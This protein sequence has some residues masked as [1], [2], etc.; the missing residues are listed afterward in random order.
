MASKRRSATR[1][2]RSNFLTT[3]R[4]VTAG[5]GCCALGTD[6]Q[7]ECADSHPS[8]QA[9]QL[10]ERYKREVVN[11][12][13][14]VCDDFY[15]ADVGEL[16]HVLSVCLNR[17]ALTADSAWEGE[18]Q[19]SRVH[20]M[21]WAAPLLPYVRDG[22]L[23]SVNCLLAFDLHYH[24]TG[25]YGGA[26]MLFADF[27]WA[28]HMCTLDMILQLKDDM[29]ELAAVQDDSS[30]SPSLARVASLFR[31]LIADSDARENLCFLLCLAW[32][33]V[34]LSTMS[35]CRRVYDL[36]CVPEALRGKS[37]AEI[38]R[39]AH[40]IEQLFALGPLAMPAFRESFQNM[41][42]L[43]SSKRVEVF[44]SRGRLQP[45]GPLHSSLAER[46]CVNCGHKFTIGERD[47]SVLSDHTGRLMTWDR[48]TCGSRS[49]VAHLQKLQGQV[50][51]LLKTFRALPQAGV[52]IPSAPFDPDDYCGPL[53]IETQLFDSA[54]F[55]AEMERKD[56]TDTTRIETIALWYHED[57]S[58]YGNSDVR[59]YS[60]E[61]VFQQACANN[62]F[63][64]CQARNTTYG[65][66]LYMMHILDVEY[67]TKLHSDQYVGQR[68]KHA[69]LL[70]IWE[71]MYSKVSGTTAGADVDAVQ[72]RS[73]LLVRIGTP[74]SRL[75][76]ELLDE[77]Q[78]ALPTA[79]LE[80]V[81]EEVF[82]RA[83]A[84]RDASGAV[85]ELGELAPATDISRRF[86]ILHAAEVRIAVGER[87][88]WVPGGAQPLPAPFWS[89]LESLESLN[90]PGVAEAA[91]VQS[92][93]EAIRPVWTPRRESEHH[94]E[95][96]ERHLQP[97]DALLVRRAA[98]TVRSIRSY[99]DTFSPTAMRNYSALRE[100]IWYCLFGL[101]GA[102]RDWHPDPPHGK[103]K[104]CEAFAAKRDDLF[105][106]LR[107]PATPADYTPMQT[108]CLEV[109][110]L[111]AR[112][113]DNNV[114]EHC[115]YPV[116]LDLKHHPP[117]LAHP[118]KP[119]ETD[120]TFQ[121]PHPLPRWGC[122]CL[123]KPRTTTDIYTYPRE[124]D[125]DHLA[126]SNQF[127]PGD[128]SRSDLCFLP[129]EDVIVRK[130]RQT[131]W[132]NISFH[133][134]ATRRLS[135]LEGAPPDH[136][137][138]ILARVA[139]KLIPRKLTT[140]VTFSPELPAARLEDL[141]LSDGPE[142]V[143]HHV[144]GNV[145][146][147]GWRNHKLEKYL[148]VLVAAVNA[149]RVTDGVLPFHCYLCGGDKNQ[150]YELP[151]S[152]NVPGLKGE[153]PLSPLKWRMSRSP[154]AGVATTSIQVVFEP[155]GCEK[156]QSVAAL[157]AQTYE[158]EV[159]LE[160]ELEWADV[161]PTFKHAPAG[162]CVYTSNRSHFFIPCELHPE[163]A[164]RREWRTYKWERIWNAPII[165][166]PKSD[167]LSRPCPGM[168]PGFVCCGEVH[169]H[170]CKHCERVGAREKASIFY[171]PN[172]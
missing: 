136:L 4:L 160:V 94:A 156:F 133:E 28:D 134:Y 45:D 132:Q 137:L 163:N 24:E 47:C 30:S 87:T 138:R 26:H 104:G 91:H 170:R 17:L 8:I 50:V 105:Y 100:T 43:E 97:A 35:Y 72:R 129:P 32:H 18:R 90:G 169:K 124:G 49:Q 113:M 165:R 120:R 53:M 171:L 153:E 144:D 152:A 168:V 77:M 111:Y 41:W 127:S 131:F 95:E 164:V 150:P 56:V 60:A 36:H 108:L 125:I 31:L 145:G 5:G 103:Y 64:L 62:C 66:L 135:E 117:P 52:A 112:F 11:R 40:H 16:V 14:D 99:L 2:T 107:L 106:S 166:L 25:G 79:Q 115:K 162:M 123:L 114:C 34:F 121:N 143:T 116:V 10:P 46:G 157:A 1:S 76:K 141:G 13:R 84:I 6:L 149:M 96:D 3:D 21:A 33:R 81:W 88:V 86:S 55:R 89:A 65:D 19:G 126:C 159:E 70:T 15:Q 48:A 161:L 146:A 109:L 98:G 67:V 155:S 58:K 74:L 61:T 92:A 78:I 59:A 101:Y 22:K 7:F 148:P 29:E 130:L 110:G 140:S 167:D 154:P 147:A 75:S 51:D 57:D 139:R 37:E 172:N 102:G 63:P 42:F 69:E 73:N 158:G 82:E 20:R 27:T 128:I 118:L 68:P 83:E 119:F 54:L 93:L 23:Y 44:R 85:E 122:V 151:T 80:Q 39:I 9:L 38:E 71:D 142:G 12:V